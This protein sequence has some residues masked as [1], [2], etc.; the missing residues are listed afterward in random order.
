MTSAAKL[1]DILVCP[2]CKGKL[3][4]V[5][6][7]RG[8]LCNRCQLKFPVREGIP[9]MLVEEAAD[10]RSPQAAQAPAQAHAREFP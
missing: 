8:L 4:Q 7:G 1:L 5:E 9:I 10:M 6:G 2:Q 3:A